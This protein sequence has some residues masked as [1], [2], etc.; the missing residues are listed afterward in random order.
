MADVHFVVWCCSIGPLRVVVVEVNLSAKHVEAMD[1]VEDVE[2]GNVS[3]VAET[4]D[5]GPLGND[6][7]VVADIADVLG[8][9]WNW[10][11]VS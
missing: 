5:F 3:I 2:T 11:D 6:I 10:I 4:V 7:R 8:G 9:Y 1:L